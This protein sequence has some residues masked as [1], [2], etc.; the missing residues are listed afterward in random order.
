MNLLQGLGADFERARTDAE[1]RALSRMCAGAFSGP[2]MRPASEPDV[3]PS[4]W[5]Y[6][7][8]LPGCLAAWL[9]GYLAAWL[10]SFLASWLLGCLAGTPTASLAC[11]LPDLLL[12]GHSVFDCH[13]SVLSPFVVMAGLKYLH[14]WLGLNPP[15]TGGGASDADAHEVRVRR[16]HLARTRVART[17]VRLRL[18]SNPGV[19]RLTHPTF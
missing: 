6:R 16:L 18:P 7:Q 4:D 8:M 10:P 15:A 17:P 1:R 11:Q 12:Q 9:P 3:W 19:R 13:S 14:G 5:L 2:C